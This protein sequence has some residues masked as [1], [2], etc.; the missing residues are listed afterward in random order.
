VHCIR[1]SFAVIL[2]FSQLATVVWCRNE[3]GPYLKDRNG[4]EAIEMWIW[5]LK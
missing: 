3:T 4:L 5:F 1:I 2:L